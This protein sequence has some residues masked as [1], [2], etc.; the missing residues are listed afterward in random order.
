[1]YK[2]KFDPTKLEEYI[3]VNIGSKSGPK[4]FKI[5]KGTYEIKIKEIEKLIRQY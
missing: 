3:E 4:I 1:M 5:G 2:Q